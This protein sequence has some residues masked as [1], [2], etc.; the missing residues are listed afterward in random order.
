[1]RERGL[2]LLDIQWVT[3]HLAQFGA[4]EMPREEYLM[5]LSEVIDQPREFV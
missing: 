3:P 1:M 5:R 4:V 2:S